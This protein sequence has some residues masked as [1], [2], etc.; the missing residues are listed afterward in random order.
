MYRSMPCVLSEAFLCDA[1]SR[2]CP[3]IYALLS[4]Q[5]FYKAIAKRM[6]LQQENTMTELPYYRT[7]GDLAG[8][9]FGRLLKICH[10][11]EFTLVFK[12]VLVIMRFITK[13]QIECGGNL[14]G[15]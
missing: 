15:L 2:F 13:W 5:V 3:F 10:L 4:A 14:T 6:M 12:P 9:Y 11:A 7:A 8:R 1:K